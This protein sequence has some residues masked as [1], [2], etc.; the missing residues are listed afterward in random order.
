MSH[1]VI[2]L[3]YSVSIANVPVK[4]LKMRRPKVR[5]I[6]ASEKIAGKDESEQE[7][8]LFANLLEQPID[9]LLDL[10]MI[11]YRKVQKA[12]AGFFDSAAETAAKQS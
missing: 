5:D 4:Q 8:I 9:V 2:D 1:V 12:Y 6:L 3:Q 10:D 11:D 7:R